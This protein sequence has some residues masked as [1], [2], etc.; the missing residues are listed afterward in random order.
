[1]QKNNKDNVDQNLNKEKGKVKIQGIT[2]DTN[3]SNNHDTEKEL[4]D[5]LNIDINEE[6]NKAV[7]KAGNRVKFRDS[8]SMPN[9][10]LAAGINYED[11]IDSNAMYNTIE[12]YNN[13][14]RYNNVFGR[15]HRLPTNTNINIETNVH[16]YNSMMDYISTSQPLNGSSNL[17]AQYKNFNK[18]RNDLSNSKNTETDNLEKEGSWSSNPLSLHNRNFAGKAPLSS[19]VTSSRSIDNP[20]FNPNIYAIPS[21]KGKGHSHSYSHSYHHHHHHHYHHDNNKEGATTSTTHQGNNLASSFSNIPKTEEPLNIDVIDK[22]ESENEPLLMNNSINSS[23]KSE[24]IEI[25]ETPN[26]NRIRGKRRTSRPPPP[27][28][29]NSFYGS[30]SSSN[31]SYNISSPINSSILAKTSSYIPDASLPYLVKTIDSH[32]ISDENT[33]DSVENIYKIYN[34]KGGDYARDIYNFNEKIK[35][36]ILNKRSKSEPN[37]YQLNKKKE[38]DFNISEISIPG[39]FRREFIS[40]KAKKQGKLP[41]HWITSNFIDFLALYGHYA[42]DDDFDEDYSSDDYDT[43]SWDEESEVGDEMNVHKYENDIYNNYFDNESLNIIETQSSFEVLEGRHQAHKKTR[44]NI[45]MENITESTPLLDN[46]SQSPL[47]KYKKHNNHL[48]HNHNSNTTTTNNNNSNSQTGTASE[49]KTLFL[50][51]KAFVGTGILFLP[52]AFSNGGLL[53]SLVLLAFS[54]WLT[55]FTMILLIRCSEKF[56]GSYGDIGKQLFGKPFKVMIQTSIAITQS[57]FCCAYIIFILQSIQ[58]IIATASN[59][60]LIIPDWIIIAI[61]VLIYI[62]LSWIRKIQNFSF[63]SLIADIFILI[64]LLYIIFSDLLIISTEGPSNNFYFFNQEKF[65]LFMGTAIYAFEGIGLI[66]PLQRSMKEPEKFSKVLKKSMYIISLAMFTVG[67]LSYYIFGDKVNTIIFMNVFPDSAIGT[68]VRAL[69]TLAI[70]FSFPL[71]CYSGIHIIEPLFIPRTRPFKSFN[72]KRRRNNQL[73]YSSINPSNSTEMLINPLN[74]TNHYVSIPDEENQAIITPNSSNTSINN[75]NINNNGRKRKRDTGKNS[76]VIKWMKNI[77]RAAFVSTLG[78]ISYYGASNLDNF[79]SIIGSFACIPLM[80]IYPAL[81]H[82]HGV[83]IKKSEKLI[84]ILIIIFG[85][86]ST[87]WI[88]KLSLEQWK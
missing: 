9:A 3:K 56:G 10:T 55:Y 66:I 13:M 22:Y 79:V 38:G 82:Y 85:L 81:L 20:L 74:N 51:L 46:T 17:L 80:F 67:G 50:L 28:P 52:K 34:M 6:I 2:F 45:E 62:P 77:F 47:N 23:N 24:A 41:P 33:E 71:T 18:R 88:T 19:S 84:D 48:H 75:I 37:L 68:I 31:Y 43:D 49:G 87:I 42:G 29:I 59:N 57:G 58:S 27:S 63:T 72:L 44:I 83:A 11:N 73:N 5:D 30:F 36:S 70:V 32:L 65:P 4:D 54:G 1:M 40:T 14:F 35:R 86:I 60:T 16:R 8:Y 64:G 26:R 78:F 7:M 15:T 61:Q 25:K 39:G 76:K 12:Y 69:Y 21:Y 53:F